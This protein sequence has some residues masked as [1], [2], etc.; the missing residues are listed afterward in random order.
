MLLLTS[1]KDDI[2]YCLNDNKFFNNVE[3][4]CK[5]KCFYVKSNIINN[6]QDICHNNCIID[7][8]YNKKNL[9]IFKRKTI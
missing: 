7:N 6:N 9:I 3:N 4:Y 8:C 1:C 5:S 2:N